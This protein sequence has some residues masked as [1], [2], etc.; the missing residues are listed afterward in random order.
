MLSILIP[1]YNYRISKLVFEIHKQAVLEHITFEIL[2]LEDGST[3]YVKDNN[4][5][6]ENLNHCRSIISKNNI[7]RTAARD[8]LAHEATYNWLLFLDADVFP[9][10]DTFIKDYG[11]AMHLGAEAIYG[12]FAYE[13]TAPK[14]EYMLRWKYGSTYEEVD[15]QTRNLKPYRIV[16][17]ANFLI[18]KQVFNTIN[19]RII[20]KG[21]GLDNYFGALLKTENITVSHI[22]NEVIHHGLDTNMTYLKKI[23][24][25]VAELLWLYYNK[26]DFYHDNSLLKTFS[27]LKKYKLNI[28]FSM[29]YKAFSSSIKKNLTG[30]TPKML[31]L[32]LYKVSYMC[33]KDLA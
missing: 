12:G 15:A 33:Y 7:G 17:S 32:Q 13:N 2:Y 3:A 21:Y 28:L 10:K 23:E 4:S 19:S 22:N 27:T 9:K 16:I 11:A 18:Q 30:T 29:F 8:M 5:K 25:A 6:L 20:R 1:V 24:D 26:P 14:L 31:L